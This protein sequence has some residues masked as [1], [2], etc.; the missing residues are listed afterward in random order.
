MVEKIKDLLRR[1]ID[2]L[3]NNLLLEELPGYL[4][5]QLDTKGAM[6]A[7]TLYLL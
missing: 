4:L 7:D 5:N 2:R 3:I 6:G 1:G